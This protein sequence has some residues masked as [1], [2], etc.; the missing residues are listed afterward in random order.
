MALLVRQKMALDLP[1]PF[2]GTVEIDETYVGGSQYNKR[3]GDRVSKRG[4]GTSKQAILGIYHREGKQVVTILL[5]NLKMANITSAIRRH[6]H[7]GSRVCTDT[8][9]I[10]KNL[11]KWYRHERVNHLKGEYVR[12]DVH[13]NGIEGFWGCLKRQLRSIGGIRRERL[14]LYVAEQTWRHNH[15]HRSLDEQAEMLFNL[16][17][18]K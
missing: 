6:V 12:G 2:I 16:V 9:M 4:H 14:G 1:P 3:K 15:R 7:E 10:Y 13:T 5:P 17:A 8:F 11:E 18:E